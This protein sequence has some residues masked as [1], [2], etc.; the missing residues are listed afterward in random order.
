MRRLVK[1]PQNELNELGDRLVRLIGLRRHPGHNAGAGRR[2]EH[3][4]LRVRLL[5][6]ALLITDHP[7][8]LEALQ[9]EVPVRAEVLQQEVLVHHL[10]HLAGAAAVAADIKF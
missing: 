4:A 5:L 7:G 9:Q 8:E 10:A 6:V 2:E 1:H 3:L